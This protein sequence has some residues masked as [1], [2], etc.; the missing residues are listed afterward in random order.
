MKRR[1]SFATVVA[2]L[3]LFIALG[4]PAEAQRLL[5]RGSVNSATV[6]DRTLKVRDL[7]RKTVRELRQTRNNSI[8]E[9]KLANRSVTPGKL[10]MGSVGSAA[11]A[12]RSVGAVDLMTGTVSGGEVADGSLTG[13]DLGR[14]W[15]RFRV[16]VPEVDAGECWSGEPTGLA[17]EAAGADISQDLV[18]VTPD[19]GWP[20]NRL[21]FT[22]RNSA[23]RSRFVL[24]GCN[25]TLLDVPAFEVGFRYLVIDLP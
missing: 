13:A 2:L 8:T 12:D 15:G 14:Y 19:S 25:R 3:A 1:P 24:A 7:S 16:Q 9:A 17:P 6:K 5:G 23:L 11:I 4:G 18:L 22:V 10:S 21:A 20:E